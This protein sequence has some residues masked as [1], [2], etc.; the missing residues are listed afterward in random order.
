MVGGAGAPG[1]T[2]TAAA[3]APA[4]LAP[5]RTPLSYAELDILVGGTAAGLRTSG[6]G[7]ETRVALLVENGPEAA[8]AFLT[9]AAAATAAPLNPAYGPEE[10][11]FYLED[12]HAEAVVVGASLETSA[13]DV[14][15]ARG[16]RVLDLHVDASDPAGAFAL[17]G[18][19]PGTPPSGGPPPDAV[20]LVLH[21]SGTTS[22]P[23]PATWRRCSNS[24]RRTVA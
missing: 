8:S 6:I 24:R 2:G 19:R 7:P 23:K 22:R 10:L 3:Q 21:T 20:A 17:D 1:R 12:I 18:E 13:R 4:I 15:R 9:V 11:A 14:A 16:I 5:G